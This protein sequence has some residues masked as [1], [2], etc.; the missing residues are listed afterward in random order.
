MKKR[1]WECECCCSLLVTLP[2]DSAEDYQCPQCAKSKCEHGGKY[3][4]VDREYFIRE[5]LG[6]EPKAT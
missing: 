1:F 2:Q 3:K 4:E 5:A 6:A